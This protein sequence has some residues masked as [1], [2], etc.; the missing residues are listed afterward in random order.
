MVRSDWTVIKIENYIKI[1]EVV[2]ELQP[3][4]CRRKK[5]ILILQ[6]ILSISSIFSATTYELNYKRQQKL[7]QL[8]ICHEIY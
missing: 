4:L 5:V 8:W 2:S 3:F 6:N 7:K 1:G